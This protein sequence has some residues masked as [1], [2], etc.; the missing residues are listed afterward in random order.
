MLPPPPNIQ[1]SKK[2]LLIIIILFPLFTRAQ[3]QLLALTPSNATLAHGYKQLKK[4]IWAEIKATKSYEWVLN[5]YSNHNI[6]LI[7][8][9]NK[10]TGQNFLGSSSLWKPRVNQLVSSYHIVCHSFVANKQTIV[11]YRK[12]F[13][14]ANQNS[15]KNEKFVESYKHK[16]LER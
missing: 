15:R 2:I 6:Y 5:W 10:I 16:I 13:L 4:N 9:L 8:C 3:S 7:P 11:I 14:L 1:I 12:L